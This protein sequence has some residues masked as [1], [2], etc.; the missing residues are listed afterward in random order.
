MGQMADMSDTTEFADIE[1]REAALIQG[2]AAVNLTALVTVM[3]PSRDELKG[4]VEQIKR[5][6]GRCACEARVLHSVQA[7]AFVAAA[8]PLGRAI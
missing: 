7:A 3:A 1:A 2:H 4:A 8:L 6:A 5:D